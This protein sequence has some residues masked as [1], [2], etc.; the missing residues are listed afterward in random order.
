MEHFLN[1]RTAFDAFGQGVFTHRLDDFEEVAVLAAVFVNR[2]SASDY[3]S[4]LLFP[5]RYLLES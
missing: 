3:R 4:A 2:H 5:S 1:G